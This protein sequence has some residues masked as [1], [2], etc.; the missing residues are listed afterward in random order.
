MA[1]AAKRPLVDYRTVSPA[2]FDVLRMPMLAGRAFMTA[3]Q[4]GSDQVVIVSGSMA[5]KYWPGGNAMGR[6]VRIGDRAWMTVV[7]VCGDVIHDPFDR[8]NAPTLYRPLAQ[9]RT[10]YLAFAL[11]TPADPLALAGD[12][13]RAIARVDATPPLFDL[14][15]MRQVL[16]EKTVGIQFIAGVMGTFAALA[17]VVAVLGL[18]AVMT[19]LVA[20]RV[21]EIGLR[22][23]LGAT[24]ADVSRPALGQAARLTLAGVAIGLALAIALGRLMEAVLLGIISADPRQSVALAVMLAATALASS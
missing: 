4:K 8:R 6:R 17:L 18:Y 10:D 2:Y 20:L 16:R 19:Y 14:M 22:M 1:D 3:D 12:V 13:R 9:A 11:R 15:P 23:A 7:G 24:P 5:R 21:R